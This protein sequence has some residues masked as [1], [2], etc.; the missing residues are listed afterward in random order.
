MR[1]LWCRL[2]AC[3]NVQDTVADLGLNTAQPLTLSWTA[4]AGFVLAERQIF[5][6]HVGAH[7]CEGGRRNT[8]SSSA[9]FM[10]GKSAVRPLGWTVRA[11]MSPTPTPYA[12]LAVPV[13]MF[14]AR[15]RKLRCRPHHTSTP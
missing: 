1:L 6:R 3:G 5:V 11:K 7:G 2:G 15:I 13:T 9:G 4:K 12:V 14:V 8:G 10:E